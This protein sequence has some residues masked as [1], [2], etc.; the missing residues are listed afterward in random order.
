MGKNNLRHWYEVVKLLRTRA[1]FPNIS[2]NER[3]SGNLILQV[4]RTMEAYGKTW[5]VPR[6]RSCTPWTRKSHKLDDKA[7]KTL[8]CKAE[9]I[10]NNWPITKVCNDP[11][12]FQALTPN[13]LILGR[14]GET[15]PPGVF[16]KHDCYSRRRWKYVQYLADVFWSRWT[17]EYL[18][19]LQERQKWLR[20]S[21][22]VAVGDVVLL[23]D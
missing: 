17:K 3:S 10:L 11:N 5:F 19:L 18:P 14:Q 8:F 6:A 2:V 9:S 12:Y 16:I 13:H 4:P 20:P 21:K 22:N 1:R 15:P 7:L 23:E